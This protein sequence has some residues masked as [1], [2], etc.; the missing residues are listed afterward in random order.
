MNKI[1]DKIIKCDVVI[2]GA[3]V[4]GV[5]AAV[6]VARNNLQ[7]LLVEKKDYVG[8]AANKCMHK[9][10]CGLYMNNRQ[11]DCD[12]DNT[13]NKGITRELIQFLKS[14]HNIAKV[15][16]IGKVFVLPLPENSLVMFLTNLLE[17][18]RNVNFLL[19]TEIYKIN[20]RDNK[21]LSLS[22]KKGEK[23]INIIPKIVIDCSGDSVVSRLAEI[24]FLEV[25]EV[26]RQ[27][28]GYIAKIVRVSNGDESLM[29]K[30]PYLAEKFV[31]FK[32][33][34]DFLKYTTYIQGDTSQEGY[35]KMNIPYSSRGLKEEYL[36]RLFEFITGHLREMKNAQVEKTSEEVFARDGARMEG[37]Y[38]LTEEDVLDARKFDDGVVKGAWPIEQWL[39]GKGACYKYVRENDYY[40]I[41]ER[42]LKS[43]NINNLIA[44]G[45]CISASQGAIGSTRV[46]GICMPLGEASGRLASEMIK[47]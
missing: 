46:I 5:C 32:G 18:E 13:L 2:V 8:G 41:P 10:V 6:A 34:P 16:K 36:T 15:K 12:I 17:K 42:C 3:G 31:S 30:V 4:S 25:G 47:K 1:T 26:K 43:K 19:N 35:L 45:K 11:V 39:E 29:I 27:L 24:P 21:L 38:A 9:A 14:R 44:A 7:A 23:N 40:E 28:C 37:E 22:A 20:K 33:V